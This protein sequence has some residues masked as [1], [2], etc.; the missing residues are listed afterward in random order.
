MRY[1]RRVRLPLLPRM[2]LSL[3][4]AGFS[5]AC[6][7][8][9][10]VDEAADLP[11]ELVELRQLR[12]APHLEI[13]YAGERNFMGRPMYRLAR[14]YLQKPAAQALQRVELALRERGLGLI[15]YD[16]YRPW[17]VT[18]AFWRA[19]SPA[20]RAFV[21]DP[22]RGSRHNR[23]C[24]VDVGLIHLASGQA[25]PMPTSFDDFTERAHSRYEG[26]DLSR[27]EK[28]NRELLR[29]A[30]EAEGFIA[31]EHEWWHFDYHSWQ[32]YPILDIPFEKLPAP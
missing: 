21:A 31:L 24:A 1:T 19:T 28:A 15:V 22:A 17:S 20:L 8:R 2:A 11:A 13:A 7:T 25:L 23:A 12:P 6:A 4:L 10:P 3:L 16:A 9:M 5:I 30:M 18:R 27:E 14:A 29:E 32:R 26:A